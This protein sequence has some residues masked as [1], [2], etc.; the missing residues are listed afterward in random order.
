MT[1]GSIDERS[2]MVLETRRLSA[3]TRFHR[4]ELG[5]IVGFD[6]SDPQPL[7]ACLDGYGAYALSQHG[8]V[9]ASK[10]VTPQTRFRK[11]LVRSPISDRGARAKL[12]A[13][14]SDG[15]VAE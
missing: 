5:G 4:D 7:R 10:T 11:Q 13:R 1:I 2:A 9:E 14:R 8:F 12:A 3:E 15:L 6:R